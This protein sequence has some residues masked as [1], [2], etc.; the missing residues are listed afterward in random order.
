MA[1]PD[2][3]VGDAMEDEFHGLSVVKGSWLGFAKL[4]HVTGKLSEI[5]RT[6]PALDK[7]HWH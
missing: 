1:E 7:P 4:E 5:D 3:A 2:A 6:K